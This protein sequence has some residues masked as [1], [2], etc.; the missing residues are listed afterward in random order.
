MAGTGPLDLKALADEAL[1]A[2]ID[3]LD[4]IPTFDPDLLGA[5]D[6]AF[7]APGPP[8]I[9]C[10]DQLTVHV[11]QLSNAP[12]GDGGLTAGRRLAGSVNWVYLAVTIMRCVPMS[13]SAGTPPSAEDLDA[14]AEQLDA[15]A[16]ALWNHI[17]NLWRAGLLFT[18]C[19]EV[20][21]D[22]MRP[23]GPSGGCGGWV[24]GLH[25]SYD[26]YQD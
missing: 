7:I 12:V 11:T 17:P 8:A 23:L 1:A 2:A 5:P 24:L 21:W 13:D 9:D 14:A 20:F 15:D 22:A 4:T 18:L 19:G 16:W 26:G 10:C 6:R 3:S 25:V